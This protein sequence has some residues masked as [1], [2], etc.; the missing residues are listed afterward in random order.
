MGLSPEERRKIY[1]E[2]KARIEAREQV[3]REKRGTSESTTT[4]LA[5]NVAGLLCYVA[6]WVSGLIFFLIEDKNRWVRFHAAQSIIVF[7][8][9]TVAGI[10]LGFIPVIGGALSTI[11]SIIGFIL[12]IVLMVWAYRGEKYKLAWAGD[13]AE[14]MAASTGVASEYPKPPVT[15]ESAQAESKS[16]S[17]TR[18]E[19]VRPKRGRVEDRFESRRAGRIAASVFAMAWSIALLVFFNFFNQYVAYYSSRTVG[20]VTVWTRYPLFT[21]ELSSWLRI[22]NAALAVSILGNIALIVYDKYVF[23]QVLRIVIDCFAFASVVSLVSI[24]PF[25][26]SVIPN[27]GIASSV[28]LAVAVSL[29]IVSVAIGIAILVRAIQ[30]IVNTLRGTT[31]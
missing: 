9:V 28:Q 14:K 23:R 30:L 17:T 19:S 27:A 2:E 22:L 8:T 21:S 29:V 13:I 1:E 7:G 11:V 18:A 12:W 10:I 15:P 3:E 5:S 16:E 31:S 25:D 6:G 20:R 26:F 24:F 4:G